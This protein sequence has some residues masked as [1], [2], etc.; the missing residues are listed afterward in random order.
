M[1]QQGEWKMSLAEPAELRKLGK[2]TMRRRNGPRN[3]RQSKSNCRRAPLNL[4][5][6]PTYAVCAIMWTLQ[7]TVTY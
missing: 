6:P 1:T 4:E 7:R 3:P 5:S 2:L